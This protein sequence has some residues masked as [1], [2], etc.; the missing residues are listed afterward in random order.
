MVADMTSVRD[1][2]S[3]DGKT[4]WQVRYRIDGRASS[5]TFPTEEMAQRFGHLIDAIGPQAALAEI[6]QAD[7]RLRGS[8]KT[9]AQVVE[10]YIDRRTGISQ[11]TRDEYRAIL[12]NDIGPSIGR[13][14]VSD[15]R[16]LDVEVWI[17]SME[18]KASGKTIANRHGLLSAALN[19]A[20]A[21]KLIGSNP[22]KGIKTPR[23]MKTSEPVFLSRDEFEMVLKSI[24]KQYTTF[25]EFL[26]ET[27]CRFGEAVALTPA[28]INLAAG[29]VRF[30]KSFRRGL[31]GYSTGTTKTSG[32]DR[33][34]K[35]RRALLDQL[36]LSGDFVFRNTDRGQIRIGTFRSN[37]WYPA[38]KRTGLA[39]HRQP[40]IHDLRHTHASWLIAQGVSPLAIQ[41]RLGH[42]DIRTT[43]GIYGHLGQD[44][45]DPALAALDA[46]LG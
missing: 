33:T 28:D 25:V 21:D 39:K 42:T 22:A 41:K 18:G 34:I 16:R 11:N 15:L 5:T 2:T 8:G 29:T 40:R 38:I 14:R 3:K 36:D 19:V 30:N 6:G 44:G 43:F 23:T 37:V 10:E 13:K 46:V 24:P 9:I 7:S 35:I 12:R 4:V 1:R 27:G 20:V 45:D 31:S 17:N 26:A 32:S